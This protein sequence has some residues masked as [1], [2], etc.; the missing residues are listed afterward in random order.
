MSRLGRARS[1]LF[2]LVFAVLSWAGILGP[3]T[4]SAEPVGAVTGQVTE[5]VTGP[6]GEVVESLPPPVQETTESVAPPA[7]EE[8]QAPPPVQEVTETA[9]APVEAVKE[10]VAPPVKAVTETAAPPVKATTETVRRPSAPPPVKPPSSPTTRTTEAVGGVTKDLPTSNRTS[11]SPAPDPTRSRF[12]SPQGLADQD[13]AAPLSVDRT[14]GRQGN[15]FVP[16]PAID[17][18]TGA[19]LP[20]WMAYVWP[21]IALL[22][23]GFGDSLDSW[24]AAA[25]L[26][27][28]TSMRF[29]DEGGGGV[30][31]VVAG[32]HAAGR[33]AAEAGSSSLPTPSSP[34]FPLS[35]I[36]TAVGEFPYNGAGAALA[37]LLIVAIMAIAIYGAVR[38]EIAR[39]RREG[40]G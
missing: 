3:P 27:L 36:T 39:A 24:E 4:A 21:A 26:V 29:S 30:G 16:S 19:P 35:R 33:Q 31:P 40:H 2:F 9:T 32:A 1:H 12:G 5:N 25:R 6:V 38:W 11:S 14:E 20:K 37:Y 17:G 18:S 10:T 13:S 34:S 22:R 23:G 28:G 7:Q 15:R 8:T